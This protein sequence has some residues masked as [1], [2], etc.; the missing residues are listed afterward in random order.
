[1]RRSGRAFLISLA[2]VMAAACSVPAATLRVPEDYASVLAAVDAAVAGDSVLVG[3]GTWTDKD[4]RTVTGNTVSAC[5]FP[6]GGVTIIGTAGADATVI[7]AQET[8]TGFI[9]SISYAGYPGSQLTLEGLT[10][11]G[12][13]MGGSGIYAESSGL[14]VIRRCKVNGMENLAGAHAILVFKLTSNQDLLMEDSEV[15]FNAGS[16][17]PGIM[18]TS[19]SL[20]LRGSRFE[21]NQGRAVFLSGF[22]NQEVIT[23]QDC[24]FVDN[25]SGH[26]AVLLAD[27]FEIL[28]ERNL[29]LRNTNTT[30]TTA[31]ALQ[32]ST[33]FGPIR[34][35]VFAFDSTFAGYGAGILTFNYSGT[36]S[37]NTFYGC[38]APSEA[39]AIAFD[40]GVAPIDFRNNIVAACTGSGI[41]KLQFGEPHPSVS[42]NA[43]W[44]NPGGLGEYVPSSSDQFLDPQFCDASL[45]DFTLSRSSPYTSTNSTCGQIGAFDEGCGPVSVESA[46]WG[47]VKS[48]YRGN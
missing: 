5:A 42:C 44:S 26:P 15:S 3:P 17:T 30:G 47:M 41:V 31:G 43:I 11:T 40:A 12:A 37:E 16:T 24:E 19:G 28:V 25:R 35:N 46:S 18:S 39:S 7:D 6:K 20:T 8:G 9:N 36:I 45:L 14:L 22:G 33:C 32:V 21:G 2:G 38:Y 13:G 4:T 23:I 34:N 48:L 1:M 10:I 29:F 27:P